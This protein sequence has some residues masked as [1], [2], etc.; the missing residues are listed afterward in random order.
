MTFNI[1]IGFFYR[2]HSKLLPQQKTLD[3]DKFMDAMNND[4]AQCC[5]NK[6]KSID[7]PKKR[8]IVHAN[9]SD[10]DSNDSN[11]N[12]RKK[13]K[14]SSAVDSDSDATSTD[15]ERST[16]RKRV[17]AFVSKAAIEAPSRISALVAHEKAVS[18][19]TKNPNIQVKKVLAN[20]STPKATSARKSTTQTSTSTVVSRPQPPAAAVATAAAAST[21]A[22]EIDCT[23]DLF[24]FLVNHSYE[25]TVGST[26]TDQTAEN[27]VS[28][29]TSVRAPPLPPP[30]TSK[31]TTAN[32]STM[33]SME[34]NHV[35]DVPMETNQATT[36]AGQRQYV[37]R[38]QRFQS[39]QQATAPVI[40]N[41]N[42]ICLNK[43]L[44]YFI[45]F[46]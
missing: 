20:Q 39:T 33:N 34:D 28:S 15:L 22:A 5:K 44:F 16:K 24:A 31:A 4:V 11:W 13:K 32:N 40:H 21:D 26:A 10:N 17:A 46:Y 1:F 27:S 8:K 3:P 36:V 25:Q 30:S 2:I 18:S 9:D 37:R 35:I 45:L 12:R 19:I 38:V 29:S 14:K 7:S 23:P 41:Y 43:I 6:N 42:G